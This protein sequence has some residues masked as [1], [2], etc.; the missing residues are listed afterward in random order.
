MLTAGTESCARDVPTASG[1]R[2]GATED[3]RERLHAQGHA[4]AH[5]EGREVERQAGHASRGA[6]HRGG[7]RW[8]E[9]L[10]APGSSA[11]QGGSFRAAVSV[12]SN[13]C[14]GE[15]HDE[16]QE[17]E[18]HSRH[19]IAL[20]RPDNCKRPEAGGRRGCP[21]TLSHSRSR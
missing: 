20:P 19:G 15:A 18:A 10:H 11:S 5:D 16:V 2:H 3:A 9:R 13:A 7:S 12:T 1:S 6:G 21:Q 4:E 17:V 14:Q 8:R